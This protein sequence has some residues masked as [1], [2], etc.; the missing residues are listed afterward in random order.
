MIILL[1]TADICHGMEMSQRPHLKKARHHRVGQ[2]DWL[3]LALLGIAVLPRQH[4]HL[5]LVHAQLTNVCLR[6]ATHHHPPKLH[7]MDLCQSK[8]SEDQGLHEH[9]HGQGWLTVNRREML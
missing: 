4:V 5:A 6:M 2:D 3:E 1:L 7:A 9:L 8:A